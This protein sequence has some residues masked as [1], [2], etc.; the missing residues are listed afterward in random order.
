MALISPAIAEEI[1]EAV[2]GLPFLSPEV[3]PGTLLSLAAGVRRKYEPSVFPELRDYLDPVN[4]LTIYRRHAISPIDEHSWVPLPPDRE[5][6]VTEATND[7][8]QAAPGWEALFALPHRYRYL[9]QPDIRSLTSML[10]PQTIYLGND[11][12][13]PKGRLEETLVH[14]FAHVW[15]SFLAEISD[16]QLEGSPQNLMLPSGTSG[17]APRGVLFAAH[18]AA[19][20]CNFYA[21]R[22]E[23]SDMSRRAYLR[24]YLTGCLETIVDHPYLS[25]M[26]NAVAARLADFHAAIPSLKSDSSTAS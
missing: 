13:P 5:A 7:I 20:A 9:T 6:L 1:I 4:A 10:V 19:S 17:K 8:V 15:L 12:F 3:K 11:A 18:F 21:H 26:G 22:N 24:D 14:E 16:F 25:P 2:G 23:A